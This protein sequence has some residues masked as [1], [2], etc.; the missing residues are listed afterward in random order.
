MT[1]ATN[2]HS[3]Y[4]TPLLSHYNNGCTNVPQCYVVRTLPLAYSPFLHFPLTDFVFLLKASN[5]HVMSLY[6]QLVCPLDVSYLYLFVLF[7]MFQQLR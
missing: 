3:E 2:T 5:L 4:V 1:K 6:L 7:R